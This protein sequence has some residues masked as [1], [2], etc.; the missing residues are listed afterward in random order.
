MTDPRTPVGVNRGEHLRHGPNLMSVRASGAW[1]TWSLDALTAWKR[2]EPTKWAVIVTILRR[3]YE[4][5]TSI[6]N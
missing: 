6:L 4:L 1:S 3:Y 2:P 5:A